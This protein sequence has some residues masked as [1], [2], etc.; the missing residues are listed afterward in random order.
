MRDES[1][2][3]LGIVLEVEALVISANEAHEAVGNKDIPPSSLCVLIAET[4]ELG[5]ASRLASRDIDNYSK[6]L[7]ESYDMTKVPFNSVE[8]ER[9]LLHI[10]EALLESWGIN[11]MLHQPL[12]TVDRPFRTSIVEE[13]KSWL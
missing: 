3:Q 10:N 2:D 1:M 8:T 11:H 13:V 5:C 6:L 4:K 9:F 12:L 7:P